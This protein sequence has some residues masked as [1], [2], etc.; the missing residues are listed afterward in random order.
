MTA[1]LFQKLKKIGNILPYV[2]FL[3][4]SGNFSRN[5]GGEVL[6]ITLTP[7]LHPKPPNYLIRRGGERE[8][9]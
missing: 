8:A 5:E 3:R 1:D 9:I 2:R 6:G 4:L 7:E